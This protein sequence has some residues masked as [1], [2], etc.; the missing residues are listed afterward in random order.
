MDGRTANI[1]KN[2]QHTF[3]QVLRYL[4]LARR[5]SDMMSKDRRDQDDHTH[6]LPPCS[7]LSRNLL[8]SCLPLIL[9]HKQ[10]WDGQKGVRGG[11]STSDLGGQLSCFADNEN[12]L[13][14][15]KRK[16]SH[17]V[18]GRPA[19]WPESNPPT[20]HPVRP[21]PSRSVQVAGAKVSRFYRWAP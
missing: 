19:D 10:E 8:S 17:R 2:T 11:E 6:S 9:S 1:S 18:E 21:G 3:K 20:L 16:R 5:G 7:Q 13:D 15:E 4:L 12:L 14:G